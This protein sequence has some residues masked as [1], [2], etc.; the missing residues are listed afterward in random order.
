MGVRLLGNR[1]A[2]CRV[3]DYIGVDEA[4]TK[5][6]GECDAMMPIRHKVRDSDLMDGDGR[7][8]SVGKGAL[9]TRESIPRRAPEGTKLRIEVRHAVNGSHDRCNRYRPDSR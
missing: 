7:E 9:E 8:A 4:H 6:V 2:H 5:P 3:A 1:S